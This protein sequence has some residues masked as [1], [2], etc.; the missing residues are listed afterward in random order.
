MR[1]RA[2]RINDALITFATLAAPLVLL[3]GLGACD[4]R[5]EVE[6][7]RATTSS[8]APAPAAPTIRYVYGDWSEWQVDCSRRA[9]DPNV[10]CAAV[11]KRICMI[12]GTSEGVGCDRCGGQC[13][14]EIAD[15]S[16]PLYLYAAWSNWTSNCESCSAEPK[17]CKAERTRYCIARATGA[18]TDCEF[19]G[20]ACKEQEDRV[21]ACS[22]EC[23]WTRVHAYSDNGCT[24]EILN[25]TFAGQWGPQTN[26]PF[27]AGCSE[28]QWSDR[29]VQ[30]G[31]AYYKWERCVRGCTPPMRK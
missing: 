4:T 21:A 18:A 6:Q 24:I 31:N 20:G 13:K 19:C 7:G 25:D 30:F 14:E 22:P 26:S 17:P 12:E 15:K 9:S 8:S 23:K 16:S 3:V 28:T 1:S 11:R 10:P 27:N 29:C 2:K 5:G